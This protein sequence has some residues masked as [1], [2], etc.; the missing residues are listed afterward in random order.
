MVSFDKINVYVIISLLSMTLIQD[1][2]VCSVKTEE[3]NHDTRFNTT[4]IPQNIETSYRN[5]KL[6]S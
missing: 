2:F 6:W 4:N 5:L 3:G 1:C